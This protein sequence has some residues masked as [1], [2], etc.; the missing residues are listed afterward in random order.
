MVTI[1]NGFLFLVIHIGITEAV[2]ECY[3]SPLFQFLWVMSYHV[4]RSDTTV[5]VTQRV[6][7]GECRLISTQEFSWSPPWSVSR[8]LKSK[9]THFHVSRPCAWVEHQLLLKL[10]PLNVPADMLNVFQQ[11]PQIIIFLKLLYIISL[12]LRTLWCHVTFMVSLSYTE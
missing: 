10:Y 4:L 1:V 6:F 7:L 11:A 2:G 8:S 3:D 5:T 12:S 9:K